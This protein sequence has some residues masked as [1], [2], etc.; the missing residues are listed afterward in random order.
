M[1]EGSQS[2]FDAIENVL[3]EQG[4]AFAELQDGF[5]DNSAAIMALSMAV[6]VVLAR[7]E[8]LMDLVKE[9]GAKHADALPEGM[10]E[11]LRAAY[12]TGLGV[13]L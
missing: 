11:R 9:F 1:D 13:D 8:V 12:A 7:D 4:A 10:R 3:E 6:R 5:M 2:L